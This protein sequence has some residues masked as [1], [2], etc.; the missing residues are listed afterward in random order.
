MT[1]PVML[2]WIEQWYWY[3]PGVVKVKEYVPP[4]ANVP[5][6]GPPFEPVTV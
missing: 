1:V 4:W 3:V 6:A 2:G 5:L